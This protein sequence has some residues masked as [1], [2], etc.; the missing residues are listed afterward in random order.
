[1]ENMKAKNFK[2]TIKA[3]FFH[4]TN[5]AVLKFVSS[6]AASSPSLIDNKCIGC[7]RCEEV[8]LEQGKVIKMIKTGNSLRPTWD[9]KKCIR[10]FCC[11]ELCPVGA[12]ETK[13]TTIGR[14][15][16]ISK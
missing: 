8:C 9:M 6:I 3:G 11:Q 7:K 2:L 12:I 1:M 4:I 14:L 10:C 15:M 13:S 5:P 16:G